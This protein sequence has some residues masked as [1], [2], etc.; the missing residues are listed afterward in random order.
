MKSQ[1]VLVVY[2][3]DIEDSLEQARDFLSDAKVHAPEAAMVLVRNKIDLDIQGSVQH[4]EF[5]L[6]N[7]YRHHAKISAKTGE[8]VD[9]MLHTIYEKFLQHATPTKP[10]KRT[11]SQGSASS[12]TETS[13]SASKVAFSD[14][15]FELQIS[16]SEQSQPQRSKCHCSSM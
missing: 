1:A 12:P 14:D 7:D 16:E 8:G 5:H 4:K 9:E 13:N 6:G 10:R 2:S 11:A 15:V 3:A